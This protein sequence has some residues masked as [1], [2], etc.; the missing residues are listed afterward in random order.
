MEMQPHEPERRQLAA[1]DHAA[2]R[3]GR[4]RRNRTAP[5]PAT[6]RT[7]F[8]TLVR[9]A[10]EE[11][12]RST[13]SRR[14]RPSSRTA[15]RAG[16]WSSRAQ[17]ECMCGMP[18][19][20]EAFRQLDPKVSMRVDLEDG[21]RAQTRDEPCSIVTGHARALLSAERVALNFMQRLS[22][23]A[24][25]TA[26]LR[27]RGEGHEGE[28]SRHAQDDARAGARSRSTPCAPAAARTTAWISSAAVL[29]KDNHLAAVDGD[30]ALAV[31]R[32]RELAPPGAQDRGRVRP[33][34]AG[35][36]PPSRPAPTSSCST[37]C[38]P[39]DGGVRDSSSRAARSS[40]RRAA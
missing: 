23:I 29:I 25:L 35:G 5:L 33:D 20:L 30:V 21:T 4:R 18:L 39:S 16:S 36:A 34:R 7:S 8:A 19:A 40:R 14:S 15:A 3:T 28:D 22:G 27:R 1:H 2:Q 10:L 24:T 13:T 31:R 11:D 9:A 32:A 38:R 12:G 37:T 17:T 6:S 26:T